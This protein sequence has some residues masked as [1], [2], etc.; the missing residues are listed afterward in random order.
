[1]TL[2]AGNT[3][4][5][6]SLTDRFTYKGDMAYITGRINAHGIDLAGRLGKIRVGRFSFNRLFART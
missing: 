6:M 5:K 2:Y 3:L 4:A 1:M